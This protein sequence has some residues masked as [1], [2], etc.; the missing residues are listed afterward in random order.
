MPP[1]SF[2]PQVLTISEKTIIRT[3]VVD[4]EADLGDLYFKILN[5][6]GYSSP[7]IFRDGNSIVDAVVRNG[8]DYDIVLI[9]FQMPGMNGIEASKIILEHS[10]QTKIVLVTANDSV[11]EEALSLG[12]YYLQKPFSVKSLEQVMNRAK[13]SVI[14]RQLE[15]ES[16]SP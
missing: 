13:V 10:P 8:Q 4:D 12:F 15:I 6:L 1:T 7:R 9:D 5:R 14:G 11:R 3:A 2:G 16:D